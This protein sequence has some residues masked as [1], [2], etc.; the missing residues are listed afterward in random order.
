MSFITGVA[1]DATPWGSQF[2]DVKVNVDKIRYRPGETAKATFVGANPRNNLRLE[3]TYAAVE[4]RRTFG[5]QWET[6]RDDSDW[7]VVLH[8]KRTSTVTGTSEVE[9]VWEIEADVPVG[10]Y[11]LR[12]FGDSKAVGGKITEFE[13]VSREF[14]VAG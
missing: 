6:V 3:Q 1:Y 4:H 10:A 2:G 11:R 8:W 12:Y 9:V 7:S 13:G 5:G 14:V